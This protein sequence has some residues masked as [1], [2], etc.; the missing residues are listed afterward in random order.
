LQIYS[1]H[2]I[3][4]YPINLE[5]VFNMI[6]FANKGNAMKTIKTNFTEG[7]DYKISL[8]RTEKR[9]HGGQNQETVLLNIDTFKNLCILVKT[10]KGKEIRKYYIKLE[11]IYNKIIKEEIEEKDTILK[12]QQ[13]KIEFLEHKPKT[14]GFLSRRHGY[15]YMITDRSKQGH[16]KI[17][18]TYNVDK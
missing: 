7:E 6:G 3:D 1:Y 11:N 13:K 17:G 9:V 12:E 8:F 15:V 18:M 14:H 10:S 2:P 16:Y 4:D 5:N